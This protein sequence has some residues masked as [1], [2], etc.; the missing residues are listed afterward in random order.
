MTGVKL[1]LMTLRY[2]RLQSSEAEVLPLD[3]C[4]LPSQ[5]E[6]A[7]MLHDVFHGLSYDE[8]DEDQADQSI[9]RLFASLFFPQEDQLEIE[10]QGRHAPINCFFLATNV[11]PRGQFRP[12]QNVTPEV[13]HIDF[14]LRLVA[15]KELASSTKR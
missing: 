13:N 14:I 7:G 2:T 6:A 9:Q 8:V 5:I 3:I 10:T 15:S 4:F 12:A 1:L 11:S